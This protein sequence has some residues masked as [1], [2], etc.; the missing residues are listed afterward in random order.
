METFL[1]SNVNNRT[2]EM[3][4]SA[5]SVIISQSDTDT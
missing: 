1:N 4:Q 5:E 3:I 2:C